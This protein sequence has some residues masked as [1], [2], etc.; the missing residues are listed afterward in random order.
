LKLGRSGDKD[1]GKRSFSRSGQDKATAKAPMAIGKI[2]PSFVGRFQA[3]GESDD[4]AFSEPTLAATLLVSAPFFFLPLLL[5]LEDGSRSV[6]P[7]E[8]HG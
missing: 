8:P 5:A 4:P 7:L 3:L 1:D 2:T 6:I